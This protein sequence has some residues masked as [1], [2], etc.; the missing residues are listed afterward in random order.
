MKLFIELDYFKKLNVGFALD[1]GMVDCISYELNPLLIASAVA[2]LKLGWPRPTG[3]V[4][5][6]AGLEAMIYIATGKK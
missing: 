5:M 1:E 3:P 2:K 6:S 4:N